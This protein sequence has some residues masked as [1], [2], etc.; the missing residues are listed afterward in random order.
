MD[1][2]QAQDNARRSSRLLVFWF[3][4]AVA[5]IIAAV[6]LALAFGTRFAFSDYALAPRPLWQPELF[7]AS[8][9]GVGGLIL[10]GSLFK[11]WSLSRNGGVKIAEELGGRL[12]SRST[13]DRLERRLINVVD[14]MAI[15]S[16]I[17][18]PPVYILDAEQGINA[19][20]AGA[21][22]SEGVVAVT[23]G[24]LEKLS[25][26]ELQGVVAHEFS[27]I[28]NG[29]MRL[30][31]RLLGLL[32]GIL[33]LTL[34][35]RVMMRSARGSDRSAGPLI[36]AGIAM[37]L[38]GYIGVLC[39]K[40]I[41]AGVSRQREYLADAAAVQF[42]RNPSG[43]AG[44]LK[45]IGG[46]G[47]A[48]EHPKAEEA[49]HMFFGSSASFSALLATH[50]PLGQRIKRIDPSFDEQQAMATPMSA[51]ALDDG[52]GY[53]QV[54]SGFSPQHFVEAVGDPQ[55]SHVALGHNLLAQL[56][57]HVFSAAHQTGGA[58]ALVFALLL[59]PDA[60]FHPAQ[61]DVI[62]K[63]FGMPVREQTESFAQWLV[64][65]DPLVRLPLL[66]LALPT[67]VELS[68]EA[69]AQVVSTAEHLIKADGRTSLFEYVMRRL[70]REVLEPHRKR[71]G[72]VSLRTL[73]SD[74]SALLSLLAHAGQED[75]DHAAAAFDA[76]VAVAPLDGPWEF[77]PKRRFSARELDRILDHL[78]A[79]GTP[80]RRRLVE[81]AA[82]AVTHDGNVTASEAELLRAVCQALDC[83]APPLLRPR[84]GHSTDTD[85]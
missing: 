41:K 22:I 16:G 29:D 65:A 57:Q 6:Y 26:D 39:G 47:S 71:A 42:T 49:S 33:L 62:G 59:S 85:E 28:L 27:H 78:A 66:D 68:P 75:S 50:P 4:V 30:N 56:P 23:R 61:M 76:A 63:Q 20:A 60:K 55:P 31:L 83:P 72:S 53:A 32:N 38:V 12:V 82:T 74:T 40:I 35:G 81:A 21:R 10:L 13:S 9:V 51:D 24:A 1:F 54:I 36:I 25:R 69:R 77:D 52:Q 46:F 70:L 64:D 43:I 14:E 5:G 58:R 73:Q 18:A 34:A 15:A 84:P 17:A 44:A 8:V 37:V 7:V 19:F 79:T 11:I 67:L 45:K 3:L 2:F 80:F 48:I